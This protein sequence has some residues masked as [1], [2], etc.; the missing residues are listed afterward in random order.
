MSVASL[1]ETF[2]RLYMLVKNDVDI[3]DIV[4]DVD[5]E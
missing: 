3:G 1:L 2:W 5:V 4:G